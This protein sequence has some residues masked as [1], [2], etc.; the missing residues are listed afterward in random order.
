MKITELFDL[1]KS[2]A[3][4][5]LARFIYPEG[6]FVYL[7]DFI[8]ALGPS[9]DK[10]R[11]VET[12][13][14]VWIAKSAT[15]AKSALILPPAIIG[16]NAEIRHS[17]YIR[18]SVIVGNSAVVGNS[19]EIKNS[20]L[21]DK[22]QV[23]HF[24]YVGDSILGYA[25]HLGAGAVTS[26]VKSDK[27]H[28]SVVRDGEKISVGRKKL[29]AIVGDFVEVGCGAVLCPGTIIGKGSTIYPLSLVRGTVPENSIFKNKDNVI[30]KK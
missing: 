23:P 3:E 21:F 10:K 25:S 20:I 11:Y 13:K 28:V 26:N 8:C 29:G 15:V 24:N 1:S 30:T 27:S 12:E 19:S 22:V 7:S 17:A 4:P 14:N 2:I 16:E 6:V 18:G 9:L 5:L